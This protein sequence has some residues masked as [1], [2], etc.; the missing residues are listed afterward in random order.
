MHPESATDERPRVDVPSVQCG[1]LAY[2]DQAVTL[3]TRIRRRFGT[4]VDDLE[5]ERVGGRT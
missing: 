4:V 1:S 2:P 5:V 3:G